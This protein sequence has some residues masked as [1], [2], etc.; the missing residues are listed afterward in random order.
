[1]AR[2]S[3]AALLAAMLTACG[4]AAPSLTLLFLGRSPA[5]T[6]DGRSWAPDPDSSRIGVGRPG[7][8]VQGGRRRA[9][10]EEEG[11]AGRR[12]PAG[13]E[14]RR[15][16]RGARAAGHLRSRLRP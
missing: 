2:G 13:R 10:E 6:L 9:A 14:H 15:E 5:A 8:A 11:E 7:A 16:Q 1:M 3:G 12:R 4:P